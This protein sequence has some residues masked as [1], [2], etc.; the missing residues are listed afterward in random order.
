MTPWTVAWQ[1]PLSRGF[2]RQEHWS[3]QPF[4]SLGVLSDPGIEPNVARIAPHSSSEPPGKPHRMK[5]LDPDK[6]R[7]FTY[8]RVVVFQLGYAHFLM[9]LFHP[10]TFWF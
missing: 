9:G 10:S 4:A 2:S 5:L 6:E 3:G 7:P 1:A 8:D